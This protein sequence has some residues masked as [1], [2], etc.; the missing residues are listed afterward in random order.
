M[1]CMKQKARQWR[2]RLLEE[3][4]TDRNGIFV[5]LTY[6]NKSYYELN[7][8]V[9]R[10]RINTINTV[11]E[12]TNKPFSKQFK[13]PTI[14][15]MDNSIAKLSVRRF[16]ENWRSKHKKSIK[17]WLVT[18][19][20]GKYSERIHLHG[21]LWTDKIAEISAKW[22]YGNVW[23]GEYCDERS[24][25]YIVK[26]IHKTDP[27]HKYYKPII[28]T[29]PGI[30]RGYMNRF[31]STRNKFQDTRTNEMYKTNTGIELPLPI[32][33]RNHIYTEDEKEILWLNLLDK[34]TRYVNNLKVDVSESEEDYDNLVAQARILNH[35]LGYGGRDDE[36]EKQYEL[37]RITIK[38]QTSLK[39]GK[40]DTMRKMQQAKRKSKDV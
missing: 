13:K 34:E 32:Y 12:L 23:I 15:D 11:N 19:I 9:K 26:Y 39:K 25:H 33:Y 22:K 38:R 20:G 5:T 2:V 10:I 14:Y 21:I 24:M 4:R 36:D 30:G 6:S 37:D 16:L 27:K 3:I 28:L 7:E 8:E 17:H 29:S 1:E 18:E 40:D 31:D 35:E